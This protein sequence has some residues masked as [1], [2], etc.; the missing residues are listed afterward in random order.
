MPR[1]ILFGKE[2]HEKCHKTMEIIHRAVSSS[3]GPSG[4]LSLLDRQGMPSLITK[5]GVTIAKN[6][7]SLPDEAMDLIA[8]KIIDIA[9]KTNSESGDGTTTSI[10]LANALY[11]EARKY[12]DKVDPVILTNQMEKVYPLILEKLQKYVK[13]VETVEEMIQVATISANNDRSIGEVVAKAIDAVGQDGFVTIVEGDGVEASFSLT[14]GLQID[15]GAFS[16]RYLKGKPSRTFDNPNILVYDGRIEDVNVLHDLYAQDQNHPMVIIAELGDACQQFLIENTK[17]NAISVVHIIPPM[18]KDTRVKILQDIAVAVGAVLV[19]PYMHDGKSLDKK[20]MGT[21]ERVTFT[22]Y[23]TNIIKGAGKKEDILNRVKELKEE[24]QA[25]KSQYEADKVR[26]RISKLTCGAAILA[27]GGRTE[28][29]IYERKDRF[30]DSTQATR[31]AILEGIIPGGGYALFKIAQELPADNY[32]Q[33]VMKAALESPMRQIIKNT[34]AD[35]E[36]ICAELRTKKKGT[37]YDAKSNKFV[38]MFRNGIVDPV[39]STKS[40]LKNALSIVDLLINLEVLSVTVLSKDNAKEVFEQFN[41]MNSNN[42]GD[43]FEPM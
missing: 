10:V 3:L 31:A 12:M 5:D 39:K 7:R 33:I 28:M 24:M 18:F 34:G 14:E 32:G 23:N 22:K 2:L 19:S 17:R 13:Q 26:E 29:E 6:I 30:E 42:G 27:V 37:G 36:G 21:A 25:T 35:V 43:E 11:E 15:K 41:S 16:E 8:G 1:Q 40:G 20:V 9:Q 38:N 4:K